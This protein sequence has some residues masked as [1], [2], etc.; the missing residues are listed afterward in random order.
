MQPSPTDLVH[1]AAWL[2]HYYDSARALL[3]FVHLPREKRE[4]TVFLDPRFLRDAVLSPP[5]PLASLPLVKPEPAPAHFVFHT[6]FCCSTLLVR[7]LARPG[8]SASLRE[9]L[10][11][12]SFGEIWAHASSIGA[13]RESLRLVLDLLAR[14]LA[15]GERQIIKPSNAANLIAPDVLNLKP[16]AKSV[17][18]YSDIDDY[19]VST[20]GKGTTGRSFGRSMFRLFHGKLPLAD[21]QGQALDAQPDLHVAAQAWLKQIVLFRDLMRR[22]GRGRVRTLSTATFLARP[23]ETLARA[24]AFFDVGGSP[25]EWARVASGPD[26]AQHAKSPG[27]PYTPADRSRRH[28]EIHAAHGDEIDAALDWIGAFA[29]EH[30]LPL[31]LGDTLFDDPL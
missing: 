22:F 20:A 28:D 21:T 26:F 24:G 25:E 10:I 31:T 18:L 15:P 12:G 9:P 29:A 3:V 4:R 1:D 8:V 5:T 13:H 11:L 17:L 6:A 27:R 14:P 19:L 16:G 23:A 2:P 30:G 7:A